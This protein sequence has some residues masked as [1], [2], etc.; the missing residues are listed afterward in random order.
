MT[1]KHSFTLTELVIVIAIIAV[2]AGI[3]LPTLAH[4]R[5]KADETAAVAGCNAL[6]TALTQFEA[7]Y[8][9]FPR[10]GTALFGTNE[11]SPIGGTVS[12]TEYDN[13]METLTGVI[14][15]SNTDST[16]W[17]TAAYGNMRKIKFLDPGTDY[18]KPNK[19]FMNP[20]ERRYY[21]I[22]DQNGDDKLTFQQPINGAISTGTSKQFTLRTKVA[23]M[24]ELDPE[25]E[26]FSLGTR[27]ATSWAGMLDV[28][29]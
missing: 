27:Y 5:A 28:K 16:N 12:T 6:Y 11:D 13:V 21:I 24:S 17:N 22:Y 2:L 10:P 26:E 20:W 18:S 23:V 8:M 29:R 1:R 19:S 25:T 4:V 3:L 14:P 7:T 15:G 9:T